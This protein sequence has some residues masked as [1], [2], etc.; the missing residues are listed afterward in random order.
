MLSNTKVLVAY[1]IYIFVGKFNW[2]FYYIMNNTYIYIYINIFNILY[3]EKIQFHLNSI[4][5]PWTVVWHF[6]G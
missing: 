4:R 5:I 3:N 2:S 6:F 1:N